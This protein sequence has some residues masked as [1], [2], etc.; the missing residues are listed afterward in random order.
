MRIYYVR[1]LIGQLDCIPEIQSP[2]L[3]V[4]GPVL[5]L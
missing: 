5:I 4:N 1:L 3:E 2:E